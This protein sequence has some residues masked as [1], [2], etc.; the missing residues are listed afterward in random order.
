MRFTIT[1][2]DQGQDRGQTLVNLW[3]LGDSELDR[4]PEATICFPHYGFMALGNS[5]FLN[6]QRYSNLALFMSIVFVYDFLML[7]TIGGCNMRVSCFILFLTI[8][9][10]THVI[11]M[12][13]ISSRFLPSVTGIVTAISF[14]DF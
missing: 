2:E 3:Y 13:C 11:C 6:V 8:W 4:R 7:L 1:D 12:S 5:L 10:Y 14:I 9:S